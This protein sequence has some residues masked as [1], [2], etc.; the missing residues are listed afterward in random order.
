MFRT[1]MCCSRNVLRESSVWLFSSWMPKSSRKGTHGCAR[2]QPVH[3]CPR[4]GAPT[5]ASSVG[6]S[7]SGPVP[8]VQ[9]SSF[10]GSSISSEP[11]V[12]FA[13]ATGLLVVVGDLLVTDLLH[14]I[15]D[16]VRQLSLADSLLP[17]APSVPLPSATASTASSSQ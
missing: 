3:T 5:T 16:K 17:L 1:T 6:I 13:R 10:F 12:F 15:C 8:L 7:T 2:G 9:S 14:L 4:G 11:V